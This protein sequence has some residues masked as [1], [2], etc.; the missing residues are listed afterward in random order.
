MHQHLDLDTTFPSRTLIA[1]PPPGEHVAG[2]FWRPNPAFVQEL[3]ESLQGHSV[4]EIFAGN[5]Y[6]AGLLT[7]QGVSVTATSLLTGMDAHARGLYHPVADIRAGDAIQQYG[8]THDVLLVCWPTV[9]MD[10]LHAVR[11]WG[12]GRDIIFIGEVTDY[13]KGH[14]GGC[15]TDEF[16]DAVTFIKD[17]N[18]YRGNMLERAVVCRLKED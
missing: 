16:F 18:S 13:S 1:L 3:A 7:E 15:A 17:F 10:V 4:L 9:T 11:Q 14:L 6:L 2:V 5:G 12:P 8:L